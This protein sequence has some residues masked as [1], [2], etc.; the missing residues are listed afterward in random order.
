[1]FLNAGDH[2]QGTVWY[3]FQKWKV[4]AKF[5][6]L[7][8]HDA[9]A[10]GNHEFDDGVD[11]LVPFIR[12]KTDLPILACNIDVS[13]EPKLKNLIKPSI[14]KKFEGRKVAI[15]GYILP[16]TRWLSRPGKTVVFND[17]IVSIRNEIENL[18]TE[19][20]NS[21]N[22]FIAVGHSGI[23]KD[24]E[25]A[26]KI[27][28]LDIVVGGHSNTFLFTGAKPP[29]IEKP[30]D[31]YPVVFD[32]GMKGKTLVVQASAFGKYIGKLDTVFDE[33]GMIVKYSGNPILLDNSIAEGLK[34]IVF[35]LIKQL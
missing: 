24:K 3:T 35:R 28:D 10:L 2:Y 7:M 21:L 16:D 15:I 17:E 9:M 29:S 32:H 12:N 31:R 34:K 4:V 26:A 1:L 8:R 22:I 14:I 11:G 18:R 5:V 19:H 25:I 30:Y 6:K 20:A 23:E 13:N 33:N 27:E